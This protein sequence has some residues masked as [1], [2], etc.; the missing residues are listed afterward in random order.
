[1]GIGRPVSRAVVHDD[2]V[3]HQRLEP[4]LDDG[5]RPGGDHCDP[6]PGDDIDAMVENGRA[7]ERGGPHPEAGGKD[8]ADRP[9]V[10]YAFEQ[11]PPAVEPFAEP[12][13]VFDSHQQ[14]AFQLIELPVQEP[15]EPASADVSGVS[16][17]PTPGAGPPMGL[18]LSS[19]DFILLFI[20]RS[21]ST[22]AT[23]PSNLA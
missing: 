7:G 19:N 13:E 18:L 10:R 12:V 22:S 20:D 11:Q 1:M 9:S 17:P 14:F 6:V 3:A 23:N 5:P 16:P 4:A 21:W 2:H 15:V 8:P